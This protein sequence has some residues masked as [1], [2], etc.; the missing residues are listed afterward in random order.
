[1]N[2]EIEQPLD[3]ESIGEPEAVE[4]EQDDI[5]TDPET[6]TGEDEG[7]EDVDY[8]GKQYKVPAELKDALLRQA[9]YTRKTMEV[10]EQRKAIET[11]RQQAEQAIQHVGQF[12]Q[13]YAKLTVVND[14]LERLAKI[15]WNQA[16]N[17]NPVE[18]MKLQAR[19]NEL[20][21]QRDDIAGNINN[22][23][24][25]I[26]QQRQAEMARALQEGEKVLAREIPNWGAETKQAILKTANSFGFSADELKG[27][28]DPRMVKV[29]HAAMMHETAKQKLTKPTPAKPIQP[30]KTVKSA[31]PAPR[32]LSDDL[33]IDEW[34]KR[35][36]GEL[37][38][39]GRR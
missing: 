37:R 34:M 7:L 25:N 22:L 29:L 32:G 10:A 6:D 14:Q 35:R 5:E 9:D 18:A 21:M 27:I 38:K 31:K 28:T 12:Q 30:T 33:P 23:K 2:E 36:E 4:N 13:E 8:E 26:E 20:R 39:A 16:I 19:F 15:D 24:S 3:E 11:Q 17:E 1:M